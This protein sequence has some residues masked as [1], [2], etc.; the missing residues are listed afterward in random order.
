MEENERVKAAEGAMKDLVV[1]GS[2]ERRLFEFGV[3]VL[4][5]LFCLLTFFPPSGHALAPW[6][7]GPLSGLASLH[8]LKRA[9]DG[10]PRLVVDAEGVTDRTA[11]VGG[12]LFVPWSDIVD[13]SLEWGSWVSLVVRDLEVV[14]RRAAVRARKPRPAC[15]SA[16]E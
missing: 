10:R 3:G 12:S 7:T 5:A 1:S 14:Q 8:F 11:L 13:V 9:F 15:R 6:L 4:W 16:A 2:G